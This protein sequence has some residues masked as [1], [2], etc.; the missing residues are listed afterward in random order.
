MVFFK[1]KKKPLQKQKNQLIEN[2]KIVILMV[3]LKITSLQSDQNFFPNYLK[4]EPR[5]A[6]NTKC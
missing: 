6:Q 5:V 3:F 4:C 1:K 2:K